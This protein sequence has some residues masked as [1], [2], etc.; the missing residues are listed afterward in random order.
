MI[1]CAYHPCSVVKIGLRVR[2]E[3]EELVQTLP[4]CCDKNNESDRVTRWAI[5]DKVCCYR[6]R[7]ESLCMSSSAGLRFM[8]HFHAFL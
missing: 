7:N 5:C 1:D 2:E 4:R 3:L 8:D 6:Y